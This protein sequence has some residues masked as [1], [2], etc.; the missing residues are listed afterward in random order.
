MR[1]EAMSKSTL[2]ILCVA[3]QRND[4]LARA[5]RAR[6]HSVVEVYT[7]DQGV[8]LAV[9]T[10]FDAVVI[11]QALFIE[12]EGWSLAKSFKLVRPSICILLVSR[13][14]QARHRRKPEGVDSIVPMNDLP[15][16]VRVLEQLVLG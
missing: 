10:F 6:G 4:R 11:D 7:G 3:E 8:A 5:L 15:E 2:S 9:G 13:V 14:L 12:T 1:P 16:I